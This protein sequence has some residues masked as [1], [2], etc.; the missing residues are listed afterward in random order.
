MCS[1]STIEEWSAVVA[2]RPRGGREGRRGPPTERHEK[3]QGGSD[4]EN[5]S[6]WDSISQH[7]HDSRIN[8]HLDGELL[9]SI[10]IKEALLRLTINVK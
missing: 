10:L 9:Q 3:A 6:A 7:F 1:V 8:Q 2:R 5:K 4:G